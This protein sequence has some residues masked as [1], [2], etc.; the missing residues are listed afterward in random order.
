MTRTKAHLTHRDRARCSA[1][2]QILSTAAPVCEK[3]H[4]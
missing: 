2:F 1:S 4:S 3:L